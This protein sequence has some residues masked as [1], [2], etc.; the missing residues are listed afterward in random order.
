[1]TEKTEQEKLTI[2]VEHWIEHN[3][4]HTREFQDG[5]DKAKQLGH[6]AV[7]DEMLLAAG[8]LNEAGEHLRNASEKLG[9]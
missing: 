4:S 7:C 2:R 6:D 5:A 1:M 9:E 3:S 8:K